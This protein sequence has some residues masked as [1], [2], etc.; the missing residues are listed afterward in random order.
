[1]KIVKVYKNGYGYGVVYK[2]NG[3]WSLYEDSFYPK[4]QIADIIDEVA[5]KRR[6]SKKNI[7]TVVMGLIEIDN[8]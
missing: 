4:A 5:K 2:K 3:N 8:T 6:V 7:K 1:M